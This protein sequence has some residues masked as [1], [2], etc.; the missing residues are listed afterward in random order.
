[1]RVLFFTTAWGPR[2]GGVNAFN[3]SLAVALAGRLGGNGQVF[4]ALPKTDRKTSAEAAEGGV[5]LVRFAVDARASEE[6]WGYAVEAL[7]EA[8]AGAQI[9]L[10]IGHDTVTGALAVR[11]AESLGARSAIVHHMDYRSYHGAKGDTQRT[12]QLSDGQARLFREPDLLFAVGPL[13]ARSAR[14]LSGR[15]DVVE[16]VPGLE[17][18][19]AQRSSNHTLEA[20]AFGRFEAGN[21]II[22]QVALAAAAYGLAHR[23]A[24]DARA[25][26]GFEDA[27]LTLVG[28]GGSGASSTA[29]AAAAEEAAGR[30]V[31]VLP[32]DFDED[33]RG[34][35][36]RLASSNAALV[37]S[38]HEGFSLAAWEAIAVATPLVLTRNSGVYRLL[39]RD[40]GG[41]GL[42]CIRSVDVQA[43]SDP[44]YYTPQDQAAV[45]DALLAIAQNIPRAKRDAAQL[46]DLVMA[47]LGADWAHT[48]EQVLN[49]CRDDGLAPA[50]PRS[51]AQPL[52]TP[53]I[54]ERSV[55][56][57]VDV[58]NF[59]SDCAHLSLDPTQGS[60]ANAY[61][62]TPE[63]RFGR[64]AFDLDGV[65]VT[66]G[67]TRA[68]V[69]VELQGCEIPPGA[70]LGDDEATSP[71]VVAEPPSRWVVKGPC[72]DGMLARRALGQ[73]RL[74]AL[75]MKGSEAVVTLEILCR[76]R[77]LDFRL[78]A[79]AFEGSPATHEKISKLFLATLMTSERRSGVV[80]SRATLRLKADPE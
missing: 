6:R 8:V 7:T 74:C 56:A 57:N 11:A 18:A 75:R 58:E 67:L 78:P 54:L 33:P 24:R 27:V 17:A 22:K 62:L 73:E 20:I 53:P 69:C 3:R 65:D 1:M 72:E 26:R 71:H 39:E 35:L 44:P 29:L 28:A 68:E 15:G 55:D 46:R 38:L 45:A 21:E 4:C 59:R 60:H 2:H 47:R 31:N 40:L 51:P 5:R 12:D 14:R 64:H 79:A 36:S 42:G 34:V 25:D 77:D 66:C 80:L 49:A 52:R 32:L 37:L 48:A 41:Q 43:R 13:L 9:D 30:W 16:L 10:V 50:R 61:D 23:R 70:R 76:P 63:V 19:P